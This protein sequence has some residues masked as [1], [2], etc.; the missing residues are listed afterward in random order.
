MTLPYRGGRR[1]LSFICYS[2]FCMVG[3]TSAFYPL[4]S[5]TSSTS[6]IITYGWSAVLSIGGLLGLVGV[7]KRSPALE[8]AG[9]PVQV[10]AISV[11]GI[12][13]VWRGIVG[14]NVNSQWGAI[15]VGMLMLALAA[16]LL[17]R[18][19]DIGYSV[20]MGSRRQDGKE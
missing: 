19:F 3:V 13:L 12:V 15:V 10:S 5:F 4:G 2:L 11:F 8:F 6:Q 18:W 1:W 14:T 9:I 20:R 7:L 16:K 17:A